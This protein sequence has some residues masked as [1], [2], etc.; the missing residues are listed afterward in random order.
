MKKKKTIKINFK[1]FWADLDPE[2]NLFTNLLRKKYNVIVS[3]EPGYLFYSIYPEIKTKKDIYKKGDFIKKISPSLYILLRKIYS[4]FSNGFSKKS[5][6]VLPKGD[7]VKIFMG[8]EGVK[9]NMEECDFAFSP[10]PEEEINHPNYMRIPVH[11]ICDFLFDKETKKLPLKR[12]VDFEKINKEKTK[13]CNFIYFQD[14]RNRNNFFKK[15]SKYKRIDS[16]GRCMNNMPAI[17]N[18]NPRESRLSGNWAIEKIDFIK[19]YKFTIAFEN[20]LGGYITEKLVHPLLVNSIPIYFGNKKVDRDFNTKC[21]INANDFKNVKEVIK[22]VIKVDKDDTLYRQYLEQPIFKNKK[23][24]FFDNE[25]RIEK[26][27]SEIVDYKN[28]KEIKN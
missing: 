10:Y 24:S 21:F 12:K 7:F 23:Q 16:P 4:F 15:L 9:P 1:Y 19:D 25:E 20:N 5:K 11:I 22:H 8:A 28:K 17:N 18:K 14:H 26:R 2:N 3:D 13:F 27:L 6:I